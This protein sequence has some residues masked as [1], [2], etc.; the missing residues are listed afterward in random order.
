M[1]SSKASIDRCTQCGACNA[2]DPIMGVTKKESA[3]TRYKAVLAK[4]GETSQLFY[5]ATDTGMQEQVC[6][7]AIDLSGAFRQARERNVKAGI[8][9]Q[10]NETMLA[11][12]RKN[13]TPYDTLSTEDFR[14]KPVW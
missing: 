5:L 8:T 10:A 4:R 13:G 1:T 12:F 11:N 2:V 9:T 14:D 7:S 6:P 3:S